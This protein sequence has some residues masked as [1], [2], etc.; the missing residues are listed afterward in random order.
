[1]EGKGKLPQVL[2]GLANDITQHLQRHDA[3]V[4]RDLK[5]TLLKLLA[6]RGIG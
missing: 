4:M 3:I 1:M 6:M 5:R 2:V